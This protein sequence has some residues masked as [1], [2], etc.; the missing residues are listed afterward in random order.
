MVMHAV[1]D[2]TTPAAALE[3][4]TVYLRDRWSAGL[5]ERDATS[6]RTARDKWRRMAALRILFQLN[7][8]R[9]VEW[10]SAAAEDRDVDVSTVALS[11][12]GRS[13]DPRALD[14]LVD[15]LRRQVHP[16][17]RVATYLEHSPQPTADRFRSLLT[18][19]DPVVRAWAA[20]LLGRA[21]DVD[22]LEQDL[23]C[24]AA[25]TDPRVRKAAVQS[26]GH[27]GGSIAA[28]TALRLLHDSVPF[29]RG[30]AARALGRME[31]VDLAP[32]VAGLLGDSD[33]WVR[34]AAKEALQGL[35]SEVWPV[36]VRSLE[37]HDRFVRNGAAEVIQ[38]LGILDTL[39]VMEAAS[40]EPSEKKIEMLRRIAA[41]GGVGLT[42]SLLERTG[43]TLG[44]RMRELLTTLGLQHMGAA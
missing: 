20:T 38:N 8:P 34:Q 24:L 42:D 4:L 15:A 44:P 17:S 41:A 16:A 28:V 1:A 19:D 35:G 43:P 18:D 33:W 7:H 31:R 22:G 11:L 2:T 26:L 30:H 13:T 6:H 5:L 25:D 32:D 37:H 12:L 10:L 40:D 14:V 23:A 39:I 3:V 36:L 29:V 21:V 9:I 27:I